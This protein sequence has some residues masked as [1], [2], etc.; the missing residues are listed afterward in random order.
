MEQGLRITTEASQIL[1]L[2][3]GVIGGQRDN[4]L[5]TALSRGDVDIGS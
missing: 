5:G 3:I 4:R 1:K 2:D